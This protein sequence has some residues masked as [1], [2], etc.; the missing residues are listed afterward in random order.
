MKDRK[1]ILD[2][3]LQYAQRCDYEQGHS[4][5]VTKLALNFFVELAEA[6]A[7]GDNER[8]L[9]ECA[10]LLH[11]IGWLH[12]Q[13]GHHKNAM[14]MILDAQELPFEKTDRLIIALVA[15]YHRKKTPKPVDAVYCDL[16]EQDRI[17]VDKLAGLLRLA[18]G[19]D[20]SHLN[21]VRLINC[22]LSDEFLTINCRVKYNADI[23]LETALK[24]S[25]LLCAVINKKILIKTAM[26]E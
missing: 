6:L 10:A 15:R 25:D 17:R 4:Q 18:D 5:Q 11:D 12:G 22:R 3:V 8:L 23:E 1:Q 20:R 21:A 13:K 16:S 14:Q 24:K 19:L 7:L 26:N 9:L 2:S